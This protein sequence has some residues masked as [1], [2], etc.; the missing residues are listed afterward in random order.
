L[1]PGTI[2]I[3]H[4]SVRAIGPVHGGPDEIHLAVEDAVGPSGT[5]MMY[6]GCQDGFDDLG[7]GVYTPAEEAEI[8]AHQPAF[9][10]HAARAPAG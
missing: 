3:V 8:L 2:V 5:V 6:A 7:R 9:D 10:P 1:R 4:A